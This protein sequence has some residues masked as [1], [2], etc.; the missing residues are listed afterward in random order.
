M[1]L[2]VALRSFAPFP[3][4]CLLLCSHT[5]KCSCS[6]AT[7]QSRLYDTVKPLNGVKLSLATCEGYPFFLFTPGLSWLPGGVSFLKCLC[8]VMWIPRSI[9]PHQAK[10]Q[11][12]KQ[13]QGS[14]TRYFDCYSAFGTEQ[15]QQKR[16]QSV[17][18]NRKCN[19]KVLQRIF[20]VSAQKTCLFGQFCFCRK[21]YQ[22][23]YCCLLQWAAPAGKSI[24]NASITQCLGH[25][26]C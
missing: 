22:Q 8:R 17:T 19:S 4:H 24:A 20:K 14:V 1:G 6:L 15:Q 3:G 21:G 10:P 25:K 9:F 23:R 5:N 18:T 16:V 7:N 13:Q 2:S 12:K 11:V 26:S